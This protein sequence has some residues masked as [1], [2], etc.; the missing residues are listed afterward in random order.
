MYGLPLLL[1]AILA[2]LGWTYWHA[3]LLAAATAA[4]YV[5]G[6]VLILSASRIA[7]GRV[8]PLAL[9]VAAAALANHQLVT[10]IRHILNLE[11][12]P[13]TISRK[14][15]ALAAM[16][17]LAVIVALVLIAQP[18]VGK[19]KRKK[20]GGSEAQQPAEN[21]NQTKSPFP[22]G[23]L[24]ECA[25][26]ERAQAWTNHFQSRIGYKEYSITFVS[27]NLSVMV[28]AEGVTLQDVPQ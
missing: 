4:G 16:V 21:L 15:Q 27:E 9:L 23:S 26:T 24:I 10:R 13:M 20:K 3:G 2:D 25:H 14:G 17:S 28:I 1:P 8:Y 18:S 5:S 19:D 11:D 6:L 22:I 7:P 12:R